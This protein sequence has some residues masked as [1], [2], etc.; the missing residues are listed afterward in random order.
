MEELKHVYPGPA[1]PRRVPKRTLT[2]KR[3][4]KKRTRT[5]R[6]RKKTMKRKRKG[7]KLNPSSL[8]QSVKRSRSSRNRLLL[9]KGRRRMVTKK[10]MTMQT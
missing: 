10:K 7:E 4:M 3:K 1:D 6:K 5:R 9:P 2:R 8:V